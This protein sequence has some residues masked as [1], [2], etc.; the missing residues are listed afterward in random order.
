MEK[1]E[2]FRQEVQGKNSGKGINAPVSSLGE[3]LVLA[4][5]GLSVSR[6][7]INSLARRISELEELNTKL[8][9]HI[10][11]R[12]SFERNL[13]KEYKRQLS[14]KDE[15][16]RRL[17]ALSTKDAQAGISNS[18]LAEAK[19]EPAQADSQIQTSREEE[20]RRLGDHY[21]QRSEAQEK[22]SAQL[23][24]QLNDKNTAIQ[25]LKEFVSEREKL[26]Q[27]I[28][29]QLQKELAEKE[30]ELNSL[31]RAGSTRTG[32]AATWLRELEQARQELKL[33]EAEGR[34][35][36]LELVGLKETGAILERKLRDSEQQLQKLKAEKENPVEDEKA[37]QLANKL[38]EKEE[39]IRRLTN[40]YADKEQ[41]YEAIQLQLSDRLKEKNRETERLKTFL[42]EREELSQKVEEQL[43][44]EIAAKESELSELR[45]TKSHGKALILQR[46]LEHASQVIRL[47]DSANKKILL[48][49][50]SAKETGAIL[51]R[52]LK[53]GQEHSESLKAQYEKI[54]G[55]IKADN[56]RIMKGL[57]GDYNARLAA[58]KTEAERTKAELSAKESELQ[59]HK[60]RIDEAIREFGIRAQTVISMRESIEPLE[61]AATQAATTA[62]I[63]ATQAAQQATQQQAIPTQAPESGHAETI[64]KDE[65]EQY[66]SKAKVLREALYRKDRELTKR[67]AEMRQKEEGLL[68]R[69]KE[70]KAM[71]TTA[72]QRLKE[73]ERREDSG[74]RKEQILLK[75]QEAFNRELQALEA[76]GSRL[77][78][79]ES[80]LESQ[81]TVAARQA[82]PS[83]TLPTPFASEP[84]QIP[85][86]AREAP[87]QPE[88]IAVMEPVQQKTIEAGEIKEIKQEKT[89]L[90]KTEPKQTMPKPAPATAIPAIKAPAIKTYTPEQ[91]APMQAKPKQQQAYPATAPEKLAGGLT[92][93]LEEQTLGYSEVEEVMSM[94]DV[95]MQHK[96]SIEQIKNSLLASG[97]SKENVDKALKKMN[98]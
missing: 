22:L 77:T 35:T 21:R 29:E 33:K 52:K 66:A 3:E 55:T 25:R 28:E 12:D 2:T 32:R 51:S 79:V 98:L 59:V 44:K 71:I 4:K 94:I 91:A 6:A 56:E 40:Y 38:H 43:Q 20:L 87:Q 67:E 82:A 36:V 23:A 46:Q 31:K 70:V 76:A 75:Q 47:K 49:L 34:K 15:V 81:L 8:R 69:E 60:Q 65:L 63:Q 1:E 19:P 17:A 18:T 48:E 62:A 42:A 10:L 45:H 93:N 7:E 26:S 27:Q 72:E 88:S 24:E 14:Q 96:E 84:I 68:S 58:A 53:D 57:I 64:T 39:E 50:A 9:E 16:I 78:I 97:Y 80:E 85:S 30:E 90:Q 92:I 74:D 61:K 41:A 5:S 86:A 54:I 89:L 73:L 37:S 95:A 11:L 13:D 83:V